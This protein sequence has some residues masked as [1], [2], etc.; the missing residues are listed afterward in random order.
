[1]N[2]NSQP[3]ITLI[4]VVSFITLLSLS[5]PS[6]S[7]DADAPTP[8]IAEDKPVDWWFVFKFNAKSF[9][10]CS[11]EAK[12][13]CLFGGEVQ[14]R[15]ADKFSQQYVY[16]SSTDPTLQQGGGCAGDTMDDPIGATF[17]QIYTGSYNYLVWNDQLYDAPIALKSGS[18]GHSKG[19][20]AWND[21]GEGMVM[22][23]S[24]P[25]WPG[26]G[27]QDNPRQKDGNT[28]GCVADDNV[29]ASQ[30]FF[31]LRLSKEDLIKVLTALKNAS[32]VTDVSKQQ[33]VKNGGPSDVQSLVGSLGKGI[34]KSKRHY[35]ATLSSGV[36][37]ISKPSHLNV[38]PWQLVSAAL[39]GT[40]LK[41]ATWWFRPIIESTTASTKIGCWD[42]SL[43]KPGAVEITTQ[44][45]WNGSTF[46]LKGGVGLNYNHAK[47]GV[48]TSLDKQYAIFGDMNQQGALSEGADYESQKC[49]SSQNGRGGTFYVLES[50]AMQKSLDKLISGKQ[51]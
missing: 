15:Y 16:A 48:S 17:G 18:W 49:S 13:Q 32:I 9:P 34:S 42:D 26:S 51:E 38:P 30:H 11:N 14:E 43:P 19:I 21:Q 46:G 5:G 29:E 39:D 33:L 22:Q 37:I 7:K 40:P 23:V 44:G 10:G 4:I 2:K 20:L 36:Q 1:M 12:R 25:S 45:N 8:L 6:T 35:V 50:P 47:I 3:K 31:A 24:T 41:T 27:N 28:L